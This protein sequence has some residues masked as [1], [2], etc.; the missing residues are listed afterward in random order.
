L[1]GR[2]GRIA[3]P[4][5]ILLRVAHLLNVHPAGRV[6]TASR[7]TQRSSFRFSAATAT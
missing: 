2:E 1:V 7:G 4:L 6:S 3:N 5:E